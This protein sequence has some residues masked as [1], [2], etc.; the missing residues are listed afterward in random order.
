MISSGRL[1]LA[2]FKVR[3]ATELHAMW[4]EVKTRYVTRHWSRQALAGTYCPV[5]LSGCSLDLNLRWYSVLIIPRHPAI[6]LSLSIESSTPR[7][8]CHSAAP[9]TRRCALAPAVRPVRHCRAHQASSFSHQKRILHAH[10]RIYA[11]LPPQVHTNY[12]HGVGGGPQG[13]W[14]AHG[15]RF[16]CGWHAALSLKLQHPLTTPRA[17]P[18]SSTPANAWLLK[19]VR[20]KIP[21]LLMH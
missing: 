15:H 1:C 7:E 18:R 16:S 6:V 14:T 12:R 10:S 13:F 5:V 8:S 2:G 20:R 21:T 3:R 9:S 17:H 19:E 4:R 11:G